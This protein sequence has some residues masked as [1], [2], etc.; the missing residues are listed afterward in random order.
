MS[1]IRNLE[2]KSVWCIFDDITKIPRP[3]KNEEK[4][5]EYLKEFAEKH[6]LECQSDAKGNIVIRKAATPG[7]ENKEPVILQSHVDM[8]C[9]KDAAIEFDFLTDPIQTYIEDGWVKARGTTLGADCGIGMAMQLAV[10]SQEGV[11]HPAIEALF[12]V[13][14]EQGL[15]G[16]MELGEGMLNYKR[17]IN[18][19]SE[20][21][22]EIFI[23]CSG[24]VDTVARYDV[25]YKKLKKCGSDYDYYTISVGGLKGGHSGDDINKGRANA[26]KLLARILWMLCDEYDARI[27]A[28][29]GGNLRNAI[30][31]D[32]Q[33]VVAIKR[34]LF[35]LPGVQASFANFRDELKAEYAVTDPEIEIDMR[36]GEELACTKVFGKGFSRRLLSALLGLPNGVIAMSAEMEGLVETST[37]LASVRTND[38]VVEVVTSQRSSI[39]SAR[40]A[41]ALSVASV[42]ELSGA[43]VEHSDGYVGWQPN[44]NSE[45]VKAS[46]RLYQEMF[47][48]EAKV[49][50]IHAGL[51][52]GLFLS[53]YPNLDIISIGPTLR[54][55]H[56]PSE[57]LEIVTLKKSWDYLLGLLSL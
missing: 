54:D 30:A 10:L 41:V 34:N 28:I 47:G 49:K 23:G 9:E 1:E 38:D 51:E 42:F 4:I 24:G 35:I 19:D 26:N 36:Y 7:M 8:V 46:A 48:V 57:R 55:V 12:T 18:L 52:C 25:D 21:E 11:A 3:S 43:E 40:D 2:P 16:A 53:K 13:D 29:S 33:A 32:S 45:F 39:V 56:S 15:S 37:N 27:C 20:D 44:P 5:L 6:S 22:G 50:A 31:R 17:M 14:E